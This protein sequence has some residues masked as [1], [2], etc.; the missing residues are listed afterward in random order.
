MV[1]G[2]V[3][4]LS[5]PPNDARLE[6]YR[7]MGLGVMLTPAMGNRATPGLAWAADTGCFKHPDGFD[8]GRYLDRLEQWSND[9][10]PCLFA[11][12][13]DVL[14]DPDETWA[15]SKP[16][17]PVL[18]ANGY[19]AALVAQDGLAEPPW[20]EFDCLFVG[21]TTA[22]KLSDA[23]YRL[24]AEAKAQGKWTHM[25]RVN[26]GIRYRQAQAAGYHSAD[27]TFVGWG[28]DVNLPDVERWLAFGRNN[29]SLWEV[30]G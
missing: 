25:G 15:R 14:G 19:R 4:Y 5:T 3:I 12:A 27:G 26:S 24:A 21:G 28:P 30:A 11:T 17:L 22:W 29:P 7:Q 10:G 18:R 6:R 1:G 16:V 2:A 23:A 9:A 13:P 8:L 20:E